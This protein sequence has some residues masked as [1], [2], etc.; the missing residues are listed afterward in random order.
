MKKD[1]GLLIALSIIIGIMLACAILPLGGFALLLVAADGGGDSGPMPATPWREKIVAG[2]GTDRIVIIEVSGVIG[3]DTDSFAL[4]GQPGHQELLSQIHQATEDPLIQAIVLQI[5]SPGGGVVASNELYQ[6]L[7]GFQE[8]GKSLVVSMSSVAASGGY[9][10]AAPA[11]RIY[12]NADTFTGSLGVIITLINYEETFDKLGLEQRVFKSG[13][14]KDIGSPIRELTPEETDILQGLVDQ[15][16][17]GFVDIIVE[18]RD[19]PREEVLELAD[20]RIYTG[21]QAMEFGLVD[22]L[23]GIDNAIEGAKEL[24]GLDEALIVRYQPGDS[25]SALLLS[26]VQQQNQRAEDPLG[27]RALTEAQYPRLEYRL[28]P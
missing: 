25:L 19:L 10:I 20:G 23:G 17:E 16:Y 22:E 5:N 2:S 18:G 15:A 21:Q 3:A 14:F 12:A 4:G 9:Y 8:T 24:A 11:D 1:R 27:L 26:T 6:Q 28:V 13:E 7:K